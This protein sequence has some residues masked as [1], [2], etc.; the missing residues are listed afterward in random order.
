MRI[1]DQIEEDEYALFYNYPKRDPGNESISGDRMHHLFEESIFDEF[2][3][4]YRKLQEYLC[5]LICFS[6]SNEQKYFRLFLASNALE[7]IK[8]INDDIKEFFG[9][10]MEYLNFQ[11]NNLLNICKTLVNDL[12]RKECWFLNESTKFDQNLKSSQILSSYRKKY[13]RA[14]KISTDGEKI[15]LGPT[16]KLGYGGS[17][18]SA[19]ATVKNNS[20]VCTREETKL[21][22]IKTHIICLNIL[23]RVSEIGGIGCPPEHKA[24]LDTIK[25]GEDQETSIFDFTQGAFDVGDMVITYGSGVAEVLRS[26]Q[27]SYGYKSYKVHYLI[28]PKVKE[29]TEEWLPPSSIG[30][31]LFNKKN[32]R[33]FYIDEIAPILGPEILKVIKEKNN[34]ELYDLAKDKLLE[35]AENGLLEQIIDNQS[36]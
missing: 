25:S 18:K 5:Y 23:L 31:C 1:T 14:I 2:E 32:I 21:A 10:P 6:E 12:D 30:S 24:I 29:I 19:H 9:N 36:K 7:D 16:Y 26:Q 8:Y 11:S 20:R 3:V 27:S 35:M 4:R 13:I 15:A 17:S 22:V 33:K 28:N 34:S